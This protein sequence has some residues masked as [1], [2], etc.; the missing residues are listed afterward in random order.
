MNPSSPAKPLL[1]RFRLP[2]HL[3]HVGQ[4]RHVP[5]PNADVVAVVELLAIDVRAGVVT[6][7]VVGVEI[8]VLDLAVV[9]ASEFA[10]SVAYSLDAP[11]GVVVREL[12]VR[13]TDVIMGFCSGISVE[14]LAD[15]I[16]KELPSLMTRL[17]FEITEALKGFGC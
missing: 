7:K 10:V 11:S 14:V 1:E 9:I 16:A 6:D 15:A 13:W 4:A 2:K 8:I 17:E 5:I 3:N 12:L